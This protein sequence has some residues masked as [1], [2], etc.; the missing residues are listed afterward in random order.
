MTVR[1]AAKILEVCPALVYALC[2]AGKIRHERHGLGR[3]AI[4]ISPEALEEYRKSCTVGIIQGASVPL[5]KK[6]PPLKHL[7]LS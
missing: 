5:G 7:S 6:P 2:A 4:R 3:G 1:E